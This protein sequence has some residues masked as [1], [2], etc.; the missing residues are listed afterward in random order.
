MTVTAPPIGGAV[1]QVIIYISR[2]SKLTLLYLK[3]KKKK[4][5]KNKKHYYI[6]KLSH[7]DVTLSDKIQYQSS[8]LIMAILLSEI[9]EKI[10]KLQINTT[11]LWY[12][13]DETTATYSQCPV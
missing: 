11:N 9:K 3:L 4:K 12:R 8:S 6:Y 2:P 10:S 5:K 1:I 7:K 13:S